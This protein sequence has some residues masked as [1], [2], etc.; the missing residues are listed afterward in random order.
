[1]CPASD[2]AASQTFSANESHLPRQE[3]ED[4]NNFVLK[5]RELD[6]AGAMVAQN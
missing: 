3:D 1:L 4:A 6:I 5:G 2:N